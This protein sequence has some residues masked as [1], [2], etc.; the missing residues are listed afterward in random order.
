MYVLHRQLEDHK[1]RATITSTAR[2]QITS[3]A[4]TLTHTRAH[5]RFRL[6]VQRVVCVTQF[7]TARHTTALVAISCGKALALFS[8]GAHSAAPLCAVDI[9]TGVC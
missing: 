2:C 1:L 7:E 5:P 9:A 6:W 4:D 8:C 3:P